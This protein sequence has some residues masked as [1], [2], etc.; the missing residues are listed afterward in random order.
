M[1]V[2][3]ARRACA[4]TFVT[5]LCLA[6]PVTADVASATAAKKPPLGKYLCQYPTTT[7][8]YYD[9]WF[10]LLSGGRY[11]SFNG[12]SGKYATKGKKFIWKSGPNR[13]IYTN[14]TYRPANS[15]ATDTIIVSLRGVDS[16]TRYCYRAHK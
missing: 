2:P 14:G 6:L 13:T 8:Y 12:K 11:K 16:S 9:G 15:K 3:S 4:R 5:A 10:K 1:L 7:G